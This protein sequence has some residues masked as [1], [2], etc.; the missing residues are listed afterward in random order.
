MKLSRISL[1]CALAFGTAGIGLPGTVKAQSDPE[2]LKRQVE[3]LQKQNEAQQKQIDALKESVDK[4]K[5]AQ[6]PAAPASGTGATAGG[7]PLERK[8]GDGFTIFTRGGEASLYGN[9]N[10]SFDYATKGISH[11]TGPGGP[12]DTPAGNGGW[13]PDISS[14]LSYLGVRGF[15]TV[16]S[17][18]FNVVY[19][20]ETQIDLSVTP[21]TPQSN[22]NSGQRIGSGLV[23]RNSFLG[24][25]GGWGAFKVGKTDAPYKTS[26]ARMN[27]FLAMPGDYAV[28][29]G[30]T[31][32]D[33]RVE[34]GTRLSHAMWYESPN[35]N[36]VRLAALYSPG[37]NRATDS[38]NIPAGEPECTGGNSPG[39][40]GTP[41]ACNDGS[42]S[43]AY[44]TSLSFTQGPLYVTG[45]YEMHRKVN[46]TSDLTVFDPND[47]A[48]ER[49]WKVGAQ[50]RLPTRTTLMAIWEDMRRNVPGYLKVQDERSRTGFWLALSQ[51]IT[52]AD[53]FHVGWAHANKTP[54]DPGQHNPAAGATTASVDGSTVFPGA[55]NSA[56]MFTTAWKH[57][58][59][60]N[61]T[62]Y[63][64]YATTRN[65]RFA[66][67]D[68]GAGGRSVT[69]DCHDGSNPDASGFDPH[70]G[71]PKCWTGG[72]LQAFSIG[73]QYTF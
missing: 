24:L 31:G 30:N 45:A 57:K 65:H 14:N 44:S 50:Y 28:V 34:F 49:A 19:Q 33:N 37:Q 71:A 21:G 16:E 47:V 27:P 17:M 61:T 20:L 39:S 67:Y 26:T 64:N 52:A 56:N 63:A 59:D 55:D 41:A 62:F 7:E 18:P 69:T 38:S 72:R 66:H 1:A 68:L 8:P 25:A 29:M 51:D 15:Q 73:M 48:D 22:S 6:Q 9:L 23:A 12:G 46:R 54:G 70:G 53:S 58:A 4:V 10:V 36:G 35:W 43:N 42:Y 13:M 60:R 3:A 11:M 2:S 32:G 5:Q 40:G